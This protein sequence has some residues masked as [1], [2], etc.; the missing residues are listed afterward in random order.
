MSKNRYVYTLNRKC[1][2]QKRMLL[3]LKIC[4]LVSVFI[5]FIFI[6]RETLFKRQIS[7]LE[8]QISVFQGDPKEPVPHYSG[9]DK[10]ITDY[11]PSEKSR[12]IRRI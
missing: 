8:E 5:N 6:N 11:D 7:V 12:G 10:F 2:S 4:C 1:R 9:R 3:L